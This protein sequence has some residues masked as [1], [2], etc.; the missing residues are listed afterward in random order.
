MTD[1]AA[2]RARNME[3]VREYI[4]AINAWDFEKKRELLDENAVLEMPF[5]PEPF[6]RRLQGRDE[7]LAFVETV[8]ALIDAEN[9]HDVWMDTL[10][11]DPGEIVCTY[12]S[13]MEIK[14]DRVPYRNRYITRW[15]VRDG[16]VTHFAEFYDGI[17]LIKSLGGSV[18]TVELGDPENAV[19]GGE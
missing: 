11:G 6:S 14:P 15:T 12:R 10:Y 7:I 9:L 2:L 1:D 5:A 8:P 13:D 19:T 3:I 17:E 4:A 16:K 18:E